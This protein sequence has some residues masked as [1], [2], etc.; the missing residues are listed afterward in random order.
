[1]IRYDC[2][3]KYYNL[4]NKHETFQ[5]Q[6]GRRRYKTHRSNKTARNAKKKNPTL[7]QVKFLFLSALST[8]H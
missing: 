3:V 5:T 4:Q 6:T 2:N 1:M 7:R 8:Q